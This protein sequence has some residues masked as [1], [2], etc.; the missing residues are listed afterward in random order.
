ME[1]FEARQFTARYNKIMFYTFF[2]V[3]LVSGL[4]IAIQTISE[5]KHEK[6]QLIEQFKT[7]S[8]AIDNLLVRVTV[9]LDMMQ[10]NAQDFFKDPRISS[11]SYL[12]SLSVTGTG[13]YGLDNIP[14]P[15]LAE[16]T[17]NLTGEGGIATFNKDLKNDGAIAFDNDLKNE[18]EMAF[19][20]NS[21]FKS[22][23]DSVP[24]AAWVYYTS[25]NKFINIYPW[26]PSSEFKFSDKLYKKEFYTLGVPEAN[27]DRNIFWTSVYLDEAGKGTMVTAAKPVYR[28][29]EFLGTVAIDFTLEELGNYVKEFR[30]G[31][32]EMSIV[33]SAGQLLAHTNI[34]LTDTSTFKNALP[35]GINAGDI[36]TSCQNL[37]LLQ[38]NQGYQYIC[39][40]L[41]NAPWQVIYIE[42]KQPFI[43]RIFSSIGIVFIV[44]LASLGILL[45]VI[46]KI[47]FREFI[48][49]AAS[50]VRH[51]SKQGTDKNAPNRL[52]PVAW[53]PWFYKIS[54]TF[55]QN[56]NLINEIKQKNT[57][58]TDLNIALERYMPKFILV[59][60]LESGSGATT[61]GSYFAG[62]LAKGR[63]DKK[64]VY[65]EYPAN[66]QTS[67]RFG[68]D[69]QD[70]VYKH[71]NGFDI[72]NDF[73]LGD[74]PE[75]VESSLLMTQILNQYANI[76]MHTSIKG[77]VDRF[78]DVHLEPLFRYTKAIVVMVPNSDTTGE[79]TATVVKSIQRH[80]RQDQTTLYKLLK[81]VSDNTSMNAKVDFDIPYIA[82]LPAIGNAEFTIPEPASKVINEIVER[83]E[84][85]H[86]VCIF[87]PTTINIDQPFDSTL[88][89][90]RTMVFLGE[91]FG[92]ATSSQAKGV[93]NS[94]SSGIVNEVVHLVVSY[95]TEDDLNKFA[96]EVIEYIKVLKTELQQDAMALEI[97]K[98]MILV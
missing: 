27:P 67:G 42:K 80:V 84:R 78:I 87:I 45:Y 83:I 96:N 71:A 6:S 34:K 14:S 69:E 48:Y 64:T 94:D 91:K 38:L 39:Y 17:G 61:I 10:T 53:K 47:T 63:N 89:V 24:N 72:W 82:D 35:E 70:T 93:W 36:N 88:Y 21:S 62:S 59:V 23:S 85:V 26:V 11:S 65:M 8:V 37:N 13:E 29:N 9:L 2:A 15:Y 77:D 66:K 95:T 31:I 52:I 30:P 22:T 60:S 40:Q 75:E 56:R 7:E 86:Q 81:R 3:L 16:D 79:K 57:E 19:A 43:A 20:L 5:E 54:D 51:I 92:G 32:G 12:K 73:D 49:P 1:K 58:L 4:L 76:V 18:I 46:K 44:L 50:L 28:H 41:K 97:N 74:V 25:K 98:K 90:N 33:N 55:Q 68:Y